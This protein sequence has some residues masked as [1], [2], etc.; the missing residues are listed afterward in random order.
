MKFEDN[1]KQIIGKLNDASRKGVTKA[2]L[3]VQ[4]QAKS[5]TPVDTGGLRDSIDYK[6][7]DSAGNAEG[8]VGTA[9]DYGAYV[10]KGTVHQRAQP[11]LMPAFRE[12]KGNIER[13]IGELIRSGVGK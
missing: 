10:E 4:G 7:E 6:V 12:N 11:Y 3:L 13:I 1:S 2:C 8:I 9:I 5:L